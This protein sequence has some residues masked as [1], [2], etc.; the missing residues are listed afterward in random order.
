M[1]KAEQKEYKSSQL[2]LQAVFAVGIVAICIIAV[3]LLFRSAPEARRSRSKLPRRPA[4]VE[5]HHVQSQDYAVRIRASGLV[6]APDTVFFAPQVRGTVARIASDFVPGNVVPKGHELVTLERQDYRLAVRQARS[7]VAKARANFTLESG[8]QQLAALEA[9]YLEGLLE[10]KSRDLVL[11]KPQLASAK[12]DLSSAL[13]ALQQAKLQLDRTRVRAPFAALVV[14]RTVAVGMQVSEQTPIGVL[15]GT[16]TWWVRIQI[17]VTQLAL[18]QR[19]DRSARVTFPSGWGQG[20]RVGSILEIGS[21]VEEQGRLATV[22]VAVRDP[23]LQKDGSAGPR[24][25]LNTWVDVE[26]AGST[27]P[28]A[29]VLQPGWIHAGNQ[30]W[31]MD[32]AQ[33]LQLRTVEVAYQDGTEVVVQKGLSAG[34]RV[35]TTP[36]ASPVVGMKLRVSERETNSEKSTEQ[37]Q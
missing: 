7:A 11:R 4:L 36:L 33:T 1:D 8:T 15:V 24:L 14:D 21:S 37:S 17:P 34:E 10:G 29:V 28:K 23:L 30:V 31:V 19:G 13:A 22:M 32:S 25:F 3:S 18:V 16:D 2:A 20:S 27:V 26:L 9:T 35:V 6:T 5:V 12:A